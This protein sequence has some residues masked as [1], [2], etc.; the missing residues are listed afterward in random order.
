MVKDAKK[1]ADSIQKDDVKYPTFGK[2]NGLTLASLLTMGA[3]GKLEHVD[4]ND[5]RWDDLLDQITWDEMVLLLSNGLRKTS[6]IDSIS[7]S[8]TI[9]GNGA[10][11]PVGGSTYKY[12]DN[13]NSA[14]NRYA[15]LYDDPDQ[16]SSPIQYPC[17]AIIAATMN[18]KLVEEL[19][20][21]IGEDCLWAGYSGLYG[22][23]V[24]IH[25]GAYNGR[26]FEYYGEDSVLSGYIA[27]S[28]VKGIH[29]KGV[30]VYM[31][32]AILNEQEKNREGVNTWC[33]EQA[34]RQ[35]Y[36]RSFQI[37][38]EEANAENVMTGFNR[39]GLTWTSQQGFINTVLR[40]EFGMEGFAV[41]DYW[42]DGYMDLVGGIL[43]GSALPDGD[44]ASTAEK[45]ALYKYKEGY[46]KLANAMREETHRILYVTVNSNAMNG[47]DSST[48]YR[49]IT[50]LWIKQLNV[51]KIIIYVAASLGIATYV[52]SIVAIEICE[53]K[54]KRKKGKEIKIK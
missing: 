42:Q 41:S 34:I 17:A 43:G 37:A 5:P 35:I 22:L 20:E 10:L 8:E 49:S 12:S 16:D 4:Y 39:I 51:A 54:D 40:D 26:A 36:L 2:N 11:G 23:G 19:G 24:N 30:Y 3:D 50:P 25:R 32:H 33:N 6:G 31:K 13:A 1:T 47:I 44:K 48:I 27:S 46:G 9:D 29:K 14:V 45:S 53:Y 52:G 18:D 7:K 21:S 15:F 38:I 28:Q